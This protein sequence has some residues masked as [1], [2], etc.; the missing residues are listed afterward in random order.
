MNQAI[1]F[2][3]LDRWSDELQQVVFPAMVQGMRI[4]CRIGLH[5][6]GVRAGCFVAPEQA[7]AI[8]RQWRWDIEDEAE[9]AIRQDAFDDLGMIHLQ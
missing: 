3:E 5:A 6:L 2:P 4:E 1:L 7:L 8:F 9:E